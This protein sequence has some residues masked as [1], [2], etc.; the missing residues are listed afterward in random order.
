MRATRCCLGVGWDGLCALLSPC[1]PH[2][3]VGPA[4]TFRVRHNAQNLS[5]ADVA[6]RAGECS[7]W[8]SLLLHACFPSSPGAERGSGS[9]E[10]PPYV[11]VLLAELWTWGMVGSAWGVLILLELPWPK[12]APR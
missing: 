7:G 5:L 1:V 8:G 6:N 11:P 3:V 9:Q 2:S 4:L 12:E 10:L